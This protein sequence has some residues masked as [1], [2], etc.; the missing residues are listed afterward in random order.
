M[1]LRRYLFKEITYTFLAVSLAI[2]LIAL[3]NKFVRLIGKAALGDIAPDVL[4]Q[5]FLLQ[6]PE[7][8]AFLL[9]VSLFLSILLCLSK[10]FMENEIPAMLACGV[11]W[12]RLLN[13]SLAMGMG[14][15]GLCALLTCVGVPYFAHY[16]EAL[17][18]QKGPLL[19]LQTIAPGRFH[20][21]SHDRFIF[22]VASLNSSR[23]QLGH[24][25]V[26]E[27]PNS[28]TEKK[29][30]ITAQSGEIV[31]HPDTQHQYIRLKTGQRLQGTPGEN[32]YSKVTFEEYNRLLEK[33]VTPENLVFHRA[34]PT[35]ALWQSNA[36][37]DS[38][39]LQWRL[40]LPLS[41]VLL[42]LLAVPL[43][44][45]AVRGGRFG[46]IFIG[47][48]LCIIYYNLLTLCKRWVAL[49]LLSPTIGVWWVHGLLLLLGAV[50]L[51][52]ASGRGHQWLHALKQWSRK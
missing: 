4:L 43:S 47:V 51:A 44:K 35:R 11:P 37:V 52:K 46:N 7:L 16:R 10:F 2:L 26:A 17:L 28:P 5:V 33:S 38:A 41:A 48:V 20:A 32:S 30:I 40:S 49:G 8:L 23:T 3:S 13:V 36:P 27:Q 6:L 15:L 9:P 14:V 1:L 12:Q 18:H 31:T 24:I 45:V 42:A 34:K 39:E 19:L 25:F 22:Y 29:V 50:A 21:F